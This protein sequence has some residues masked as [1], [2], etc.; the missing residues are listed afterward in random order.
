MTNLLINPFNSFTMKAIGRAKTDNPFYGQRELLNLQMV[1]TKGAAKSVILS[2]LNETWNKVK[3]D[4]TLRQLF[5]VI[6]FSIGDIP[7]RQHNVF[8][9]SK[10]DGGGSG[11]RNEF[12][13]VM[14]WMLKKHPQQYLK[15]LFADL[16]RQFVCL[17]NVLATQVRTK[18]GTTTQTEVIRAYGPQ[19]I[20]A[21]ASYLADIIKRA[22]P[23]DATIIA[24]WLVKSRLSMRQKRNR[25]TKEIVGKRKLSPAV[26][27]NMLLRQQLYLRLSEIMGWEVEKYPYNIRFVGMDNWRQEHNQ[28][29]ES[30]LF[31]TKSILNMTKNDFMMFLD[32]IPSNARYRVRRRLL[33]KNDKSKN[34]WI[35]GGND[36]AKYFL[37][38]ENNKKVA[39]RQQRVLEE[40]VRQGVASEKDVEN[41]AKVKKEAKVNVGAT[42]IFEALQKQSTIELQ[43]ILD[44]IK[45]EVPVLVIADCSGSMNGLPT[46]IARVLAT[47][48]MLKNPSD[49]L[50]DM[51][52]CFGSKCKVYS[53][54][55]L[56][57]V[58]ERKNR[59]LA[60]M[61]LTVPGICDRTKSFEENL[62]TVSHFVNSSLGGTDFTTVAST[63]KEWVNSD[64]SMKETKIE[65]IRQYP[66]FLVV[67]DGDFN[68][69]S[70]AL[71][72]L[73]Q[74][75][76]NMLQWFGWDGVVVVWDVNTGRA[77]NGSKFESL[78]NVI[79]FN[80]W[81]AAIVNQV[82][83][84][85][86]DLDIIDVY[87]PLKSLFL[88]N[89][90]SLVKEN[91]L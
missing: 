44:K 47:L 41:L 1:A 89:R 74:F 76:Q 73:R 87:T 51:L 50:S 46:Y 82:F 81:N 17:W 84:K 48:A 60:G 22:N 88:S 49:E 28:E 68:S 45:F 61:E 30:V 26:R 19:D 36:F 24:K 57:K 91:V 12:M 58:E 43:S 33:D 11:K 67:S 10:V 55:G 77:E 62:Q 16:F 42:S 66:V 25:K 4:L 23:M 79:H 65:Q 90:Y 80:G 38:W 53:G 64:I 27:E 35:K 63:M 40:K 34:K 6:L 13:W 2:T 29:L 85:I 5:F 32:R 75:Q 71:Q 18:P 39:Q 31:S 37:E 15:F 59:F 7:N 52:I 70:S 3:N 14:E 8:R 9:K 56:N 54:Y 78:E 72:S 86:H 20:E 21:L 83:T 69:S